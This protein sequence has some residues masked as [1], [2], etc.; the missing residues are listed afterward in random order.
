MQDSYTTTTTRSYGNRIGSSLKGVLIGLVIIIGAIV[1]IFINERNQAQKVRLM[2]SVADQV[3]SIEP[4]IAD[5]HQNTIIHTSGLVTSENTIED[6][7]FNFVFDDVLKYR[8]TVE[9]YQWEETQREETKDKLGGSQEITVTTTYDKVW[10]SSPIDSGEFVRTDYIN[11]T[12]FPLDSVTQEVAEARI[13]DSL[14]LSPLLIDRIAGFEAY[15]PEGDYVGYTSAG[16]GT[17]LYQGNDFT[18]PE[19]GDIR[20]DFKTIPEGTY[21]FVGEYNNG[22]IGEHVGKKQSIGLVAKGSLSADEMIA[23]EKAHTRTIGWILRGVAL[24]M[25]FVGLSMLLG[26]LE[27]L[28]SVVPMAGRFVGMLSKAITFGIALVLSLM[29]A[30][31][32]W[33]IYRP[34]I[35]VG[36]I[37]VTLAIGFGVRTLAA[38]ND[39]K[40]TPE[41]NNV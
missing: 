9:M 36:L 14:A 29:T 25:M 23:Q 2:K 20:I 22:V 32:A 7:S 11:P 30:S 10:S 41:Q 37:V 1:L 40:A 17:Y 19:I 3:V 15:T 34:V 27:T 26:P 6:P 5:E 24:V 13:N 28:A 33:V 35:G 12:D 4:A 18:N 21:S 16:G 31:V 8:R 38:R 39:K